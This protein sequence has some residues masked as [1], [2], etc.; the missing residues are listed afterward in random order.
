MLR[1]ALA[2]FVFALIAFLLGA[3][4]V[5]GLSMEIGRILIGVFLALA[6]LSLVVAL[7][8]G[9]KTNLLP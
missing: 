8:T 9:K 3:T 2:F 5:A 1:M 7:F 4:G 6:L